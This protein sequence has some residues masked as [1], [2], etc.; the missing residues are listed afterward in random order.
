MSRRS[1]LMCSAPWQIGGATSLKNSR[2]SERNTPLVCPYRAIA[3]KK[4][5]TMFPESVDWNLF[6][7]EWRKGYFVHTYVES[8][9]MVCNG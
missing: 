6:A 4:A 8:S 5:R 3:C 1:F 2:K 7:D 9:R